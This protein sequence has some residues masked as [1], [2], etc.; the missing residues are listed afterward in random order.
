MGGT[1]C[2]QA[3]ALLPAHHTDG[4]SHRLR[5][6]VP[7]PRTDEPLTSP[8]RPQESGGCARPS[9]RG[10]AV[11]APQVHGKL[12]LPLPGDNWRADFTPS[13]PSAGPGGGG[14]PDRHRM[15]PRTV[16]TPASTG[17]SVPGPVGSGQ[18][19]RHLDTGRPHRS[20]QIVSWALPSS[21]E[22]S[23][24]FGEPPR[25]EGGQVECRSTPGCRKE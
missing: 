8:R 17:P 15:G 5:R 25:R 12:T 9:L 2:P 11:P 20:V 1:G 22:G 4:H 23:R 6:P 3:A 13:R 10:D 16:G 14:V 18:Q 24:V 19:E 7:F 21:R